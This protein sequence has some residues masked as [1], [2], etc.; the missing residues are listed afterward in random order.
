MVMDDQ[1]AQ[2]QKMHGKLTAQKQALTAAKAAC[3]NKGRCFVVPN[4]PK[5]RKSVGE[6]VAREFARIPR[7]L[8][9][10]FL[11]QPVQKKKITLGPIEKNYA[12]WVIQ[13]EATAGDLEK[14]RAE[15]S[16]SDRR[17]K[18]SLLIPLLDPPANFLDELFASI[19]AQTYD[20]WEA[21]VVD[22]GSANRRN[23]RVAAALDEKRQAYSC[24]A[25]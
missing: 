11:P 19:V 20:N 15:S 5:P 2:I 18:I 9:R 23:D 6:R 14:Q 8:G 7:K 24:P 1:F 12:K 4:G 16:A 10:I 17:P 22:A 3:R 13:H 25:S 21:C